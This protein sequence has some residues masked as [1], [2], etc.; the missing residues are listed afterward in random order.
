[1]MDVV[2]NNIANVN[3]VAFKRSRAVFNEV[4]GQQLLGLSRTG[5]SSSGITSGIVGYG[6][7]V[8]SVNQNWNQGP[9]EFTNIPTDLALNGVSLAAAVWAVNQTGS[10]F[11]SIWCFFLVQALFVA[12]PASMKQKAGQT[13]ESH[14]DRFQHAYRAAETALRKLSTTP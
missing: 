7:A 3:T 1:M 6:V 9:L 8:G 13:G 14:K 12:I 4:L 2:G 10:L 5:G 11:V